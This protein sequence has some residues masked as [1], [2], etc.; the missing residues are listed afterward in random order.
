MYSVGPNS[1]VNSNIKLKH[2]VSML[3]QSCVRCRRASARRTTPGALPW[4][5]LCRTLLQCVY[6]IPIAHF[7][8]IHIT[9]A[10]FFSSFHPRTTRTTSPYTLQSV[11]L[12]LHFTFRATTTTTNSANLFGFLWQT[13]SYTAHNSELFPCY[14][15]FIKNSSANL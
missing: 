11:V 15:Y 14:L 6:P 9:K 1:N 4:H 7:A 3:C 5:L 12:D 10:Q 2:R 13:K 8:T